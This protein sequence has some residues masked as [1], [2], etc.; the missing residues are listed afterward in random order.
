MSAPPIGL[1]AEGLA[2]DIRRERRDLKLLAAPALAL[3]GILVLG[4]M[5]W[6]GY[7][8]FYNEHGQFT[9]EHYAR[10]FEEGAY[11]VIFWTTFRVSFTVTV[12]CALLGYPL[13]YLLAQLPARWANILML[14]ILVP[15]W[16]ALL[17]RTYAWL[18]LLQRR[19][20]VNDLLVSWGIVDQ[21]LP[22]VHNMTG[23]LIGM[24]HIMIPFLVLPLYA[25]MK[26]ID[27]NLMR[28]SGSLGASPTR[29]FW[30]IYFPLT[31]PGLWAGMI[32]VFI[33][34]LGFYVTP[35]VLGGGRVIMLA[36]RI[37][38]SVSLYPSWGAASALG[39]VLLLL[40][41]GFMAVGLWIARLVRR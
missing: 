30:G 41:I 10:L 38:N 5:I 31:A 1:N 18:V 11:L 28:A 9:F 14:G 32:L 26:T 36:Q 39:V 19:G 22:L 12:I 15:F 25:T 8:S 29:A 16:T 27:P 34:C 17:V 21:P 33:F 35:A 13:A 24:V 20:L 3:V 7:L 6:L 37:E 40:T 23:T 4:P 2:E